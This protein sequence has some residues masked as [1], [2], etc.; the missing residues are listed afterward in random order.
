MTA[1]FQKKN[2]MHEF[3]K[4]VLEALKESEETE[5][6]KW[7]KPWRSIDGRYRNAISGHKYR[8]LHNVL[9]CALSEFS[10]PRYITFNQIRKA[11][12]TLKKGSKATQL[13]A[14]KFHKIADDDGK[15]KTI[16]FAKLWSLFNVEQTE[17]L[18]L[19]ELDSDVIDESMEVNQVVLDVYDALNV[20]YA[21]EK[22]NKACYY[23][24]EDR[25][26]IPLVNQFSDQSRWSMTALHELV[27]WTAS[28]VN[29]DCSTYSF[30]TEA[31]AMEELV[32]ELGSMYLSMHLKIDGYMD[33][34]NLAYIQSWKKTANSTNGDRYIYKACKLAEDASR[35]ILENSG[36]LE[37]EK[38][39]S[40]D[41]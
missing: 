30:D 12:G 1:T 22:S 3:S 34:E 18:N 26:V 6:L 2:A 39:G 20:S 4:R 31:R 21:H 35:Y 25:I 7:H 36:I 11:N 13:I 17:G 23:P 37:K 27:H 40:K 28:R 5:E 15:E 19:P 8:G 33:K 14:W 29:R 24:K 10:D 9:V 32:A 38:N 41:T 16:P